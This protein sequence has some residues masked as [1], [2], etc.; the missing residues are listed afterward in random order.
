MRARRTQ[1]IQR[2]AMYQQRPQSVLG[3]SLSG[4]A[5]VRREDEHQPAYLLARRQGAGHLEK[6]RRRIETSTIL[7][8]E[9]GQGREGVIIRE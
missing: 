9:R 3:D 5:F 4:P 6:R 2:N 8:G 1:N 7:E